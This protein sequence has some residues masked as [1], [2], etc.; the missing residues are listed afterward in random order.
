MYK[1]QA[2]GYN[3]LFK[4]AS[5]DIVVSKYEFADVVLADEIHT[6]QGIVLEIKAL[7]DVKDY[8]S[9]SDLTR[10]IT[11]KDYKYEAFYDEATGEVL[12][13]ILSKA[14]DLE[15]I[16]VVLPYLLDFVV[17]KV[18]DVDLTFLKGN[19][20]K[21]ELAS[22]IKQL[23]NAIVP[24]IRAELV[25]LL[26]GK[27]VEEL[28][29]HIAEYAEI[30]DAIK[31]LSFL[32][33]K[34]PE[35]ASALI[36]KGLNAIQSKQA[37]TKKLF[38][39]IT[40]ADEAPALIEALKQFELVANQAKFVT[41]QDII[42]VTKDKKFYENEAYVNENVVYPLI[43]TLE[44]LTNLQTLEAMMQVV[45][46]IGIE[47][48]DKA[49]INIAF[50]L[51][52][53]TN[54]ELLADVKLALD[55]ARDA[56]RLGGLEYV[57]TKDIANFDPTIL[58]EMVEGLYDF[59]VMQLHAP[60]V[61]QKVVDILNSKVSSLRIRTTSEDFESLDYVNEFAVLAQ[62]IT[63]FED[64]MKAEVC[65][66]LNDLID[67][68]KL[69]LYTQKGFFNETAFDVMITMLNKATEL[70]TLEVLLPDLLHYVVKL[71]SANRIDISFIIDK[72][73]TTEYQL[74]D[75]RTCIRML[76]KA[77]DFGIMDYVFDKDILEMNE[78][79]LNL[80]LIHI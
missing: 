26:F 75:I 62:I 41:V 52:G 7:M 44:E 27:K 33:K 63:S 54:S 18:N 24:A 8:H 56:V 78:V 21:E 15:S 20:T 38:E 4:A 11:R 73:Y 66:S 23:A 32:N 60:E 12:A 76:D 16:V 25:G 40:F 10:V 55:Y 43:D 14:V 31:E 39:G 74:E 13:N 67:I 45:G 2:L 29:L 69:K 80:S 77:Y 1:R 37:V 9:L 59:N 35:L 65:H 34:Y 50:L 70:Q 22:D 53:L 46:N 79:I 3:K 68:V 57:T 17:E 42:D 64:L 72:A 19:F 30:V 36:N 47:F 51:K 58:A 48:A 49:G 71:A 5:I 61:M 28:N 6:L